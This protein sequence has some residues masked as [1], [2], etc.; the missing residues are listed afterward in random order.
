MLAL[1]VAL[2]LQAAAAAELPPLSQDQVSW[3]FVR[4]AETWQRRYYPKEA[5]KKGRMG[6][7]VIDCLIE[8]AGTL[9]DCRVVSESPPGNGFGEAAVNMRILFKARSDRQGQPVIGRRVVIP[10]NFN[11]S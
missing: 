7:A 9:T 11:L 1:V 8:P 5:R 10:I 3:E 6:K 4:N 2:A